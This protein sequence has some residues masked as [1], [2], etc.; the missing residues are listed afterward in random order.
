MCT[1]TN[2][3]GSCLITLWYFHP[4]FLDKLENFTFDKPMPLSFKIYWGLHTTTLTISL[5]IT[6]I[7]W[8]FLFPLYIET[9]PVNALSILAHA[10]NSI[11]MVIDVIIV[12]FPVR[13]LHIFLPILFTLCYLIFSIIYYFAGG[14]DS[15][16]NRFIYPILDWNKPGVALRTSGLVLILFCII[17]FILF[18]I[19]KIRIIIHRRICFENKVELPPSTPPC[20]ERTISG[21][22]DNRFSGK[23]YIPTTSL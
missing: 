3:Y 8:I 4:K 9:I 7:Y 11:L 16:G 5:V 22:I 13:I 12:A 19:Y 20:F 1:L 18:I 15:L 14:T 21:D 6:I 10:F 17:A 23:S 2:L